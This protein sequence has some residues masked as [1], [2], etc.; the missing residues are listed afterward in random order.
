VTYDLTGKVAI[1]TG[2]SRGIG[3]A[4]TL[5]MAS[6]GA[7]VVLAARTPE[8]L[9]TV[10]KEIGEKALAVPTDVT[11]AGQVEALIQKAL[12]TFGRIDILVNN[13]GASYGPTFGRGPLLEISERDFDNAVALNFKSIFLCGRAV[14]PAMLEQ[15]SGAIVNVSSFTAQQVHGTRPGFAIYGAAKA[16]VINLTWSMAAEWA[17]VRVNCVVPGF[18]DSPRDVPTRSA[19][20][21]AQRVRAVALSRFGRPDEAAQAILFLASDAASYVNGACLEVHGGHRSPLPAVEPVP[22]P[23]A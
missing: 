8:R 4:T 3:H 6:A 19:E 2:A 16:A 12:D 9:N 10:A 13:A 5:A 21:N 22:S 11:D 7:S 15:G 17:P 20:A 23:K 1:V 18:I 14:A